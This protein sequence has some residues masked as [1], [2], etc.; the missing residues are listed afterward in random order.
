LEVFDTRDSSVSYDETF[1]AIARSQCQA[2]LV[3]SSPRF[4]RDSKPIIEGAARARIPAI[5]GEARNA[6]E[7]GLIAYATTPA[8]LDRQVDTILRGAKPGDL[9][10]EQP[11]RYE[12]A[13]NLA[14]ARALGINIP[15]AL[16]LQ[17]DQVIE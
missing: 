8:E 16:L 6:R 15:Q 4:A 3:M 2:L 11:S 7:G 12:L 10:V 1:D 14:T 13:I 17:A 5:H 9:P